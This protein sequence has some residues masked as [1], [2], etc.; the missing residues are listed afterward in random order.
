MNVVA[1]LKFE[2]AHFEAT[3]NILAITPQLFPFGNWGDFYPSA[4][5]TVGLF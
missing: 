1:Q 3:V 2:P 4:E 5:D